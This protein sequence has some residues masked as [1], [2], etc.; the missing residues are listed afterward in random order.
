[1]LLAVVLPLGPRPALAAGE[2]RA[3]TLVDRGTTVWSSSYSSSV[4]GLYSRSW[5][6]EP[7]PSLFS[8]MISRLRSKT[9][10]PVPSKSMREPSFCDRKR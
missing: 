4:S 1:M 7:S 5:N 3:T 2:R 10:R 8:W 6:P 9:V